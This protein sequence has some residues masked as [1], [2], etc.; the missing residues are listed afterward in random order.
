MADKHPTVVGSFYKIGDIYYYN[1]A[2]HGKRIRVTTKQTTL[3]AA[4]AWVLSTHFGSRCEHQP[5]TPN[6]SYFRR[7]LG[8]TKHNASARGIRFELTLDDVESLYLASKGHCEVSGL[9][10]DM[11]QVEGANRRPYLPSIDRRDGFLGYSRDN[12]RMVCCAVNLAMNE[13]GEDVLWEIASSMA[14]LR[15]KQ[16][17]KDKN[18][19]QM[20]FQAQP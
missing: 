10:F 20:T 18:K 15:S 6:K 17:F 3:E 1:R 14:M 11:R 13:F 19:T 12:C 5:V 4:A 2:W 9:P 7:M 8:H 16:S